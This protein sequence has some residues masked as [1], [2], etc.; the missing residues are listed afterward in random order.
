LV[1]GALLVLL[2]WK[3]WR[4]V[5]LLEKEIKP[6]LDSANDTVGTVRGNT[7]FVSEK[8]VSPVVRAHSWVAGV[9]GGV[10]SFFRSR[11]SRGAASDSH[12]EP[13]EL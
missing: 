8:V 9:R 5:R 3:V 11:H 4:L 10:R 7:T 13:D 1:I 6:L 12:R 2:V